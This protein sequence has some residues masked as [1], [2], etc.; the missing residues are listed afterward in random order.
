MTEHDEQDQGRSVPDN[1]EHHPEETVDALEERAVGGPADQ[2]RDEDD[3]A[4]AI[5][6]DL[7]DDDLGKAG[8][9]PTG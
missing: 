3:D 6:Q 4:P 1:P 7:D 5:E 8:S 2:S 9:E